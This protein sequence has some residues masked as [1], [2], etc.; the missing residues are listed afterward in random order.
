MQEMKTINKNGIEQD[1]Q[2]NGIDGIIWRE[3]ANH[4]AQITTD[5]EST[6]FALDGYGIPK[7]KIQEV[8]KKYM[9]H[10]IENDLF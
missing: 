1:I 6:V 9:K 7:E 8:L 5:T 3:L 10:C 4:E 2:E